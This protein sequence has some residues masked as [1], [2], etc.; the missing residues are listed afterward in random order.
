MVNMQFA[1]VAL[2][3]LGLGLFFVREGTPN[4][5]PLVDDGG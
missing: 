2:P 4:L 5:Y 3:M 1:M